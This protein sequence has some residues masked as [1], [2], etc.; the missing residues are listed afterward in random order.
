MAGESSGMKEKVIVL[1]YRP[2]SY[3]IWPVRIHTHN[4]TQYQE[5]A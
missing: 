2:M 3:M 5:I 4:N 1:F